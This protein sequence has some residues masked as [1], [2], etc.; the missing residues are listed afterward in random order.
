MADDIVF[1]YRRH[2]GSMDSI[3]KKNYQTYKKYI[4]NKNSDAILKTLKMI[5][6][7]K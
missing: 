7:N 2:D 4:L 6:N 1:Y 5:K 3:A